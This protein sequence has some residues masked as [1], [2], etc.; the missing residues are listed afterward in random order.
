MTG[1]V[2]LGPERQAARRLPPQVGR[3]ELQPGQGV[4]AQVPEARPRRPPAPRPPHDEAAGVGGERDR[5]GRRRVD[6]R[7][8]PR[9]RLDGS[10]VE[11]ALQG[12]F[13]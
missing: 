3:R 13:D 2:R 10:V 11:E 8:R 12:V 4:H 5:E 9:R 7:H 1:R 6:H